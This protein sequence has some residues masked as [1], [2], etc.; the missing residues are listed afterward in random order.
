[1]NSLKEKT[2][3]VLSKGTN[4]VRMWIAE[5]PSTRDCHLIWYQIKKRGLRYILSSHYYGETF[6]EEYLK[7]KPGYQKLAELIYEWAQPKSVCDF[8]CG[9]GFLLYFLAQRTIEVSGVEGSYDALKFMDNSIRPRILVR[10]LTKPIETSVHDLVI[11]TEV[12]E[13]LPK[14]ASETFVQNLA[15]SAAR[16]IVFTAAHP[17]QW[18]DGHINCQPRGFWIALFQARGWIYD[19]AATERFTNSVRNSPEIVET[20][21][22]MINNFMLFVPSQSHPGANGIQEIKNE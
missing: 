2:R 15:N 18:G 21:P 13:H 11:S 3:A 8:G 5:S 6:F 22:W 12:A 10:D 19:Q 20:L 17:G 4:S 14:R 1:M 16:S 7:L 9:N